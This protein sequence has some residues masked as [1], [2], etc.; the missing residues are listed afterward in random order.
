MSNVMTQARFFRKTERVGDC[1]IWQGKSR[2]GP[3]GAVGYQSKQWLAHRLSYHFQTGEELTAQDVIRHT[4]DTPLCVEGTHL[5]KGT[6]ADNVEDKVVKLRHRFGER[7]PMARFTE[8]DVRA[9]RKA[10]D[11][12]IMQKVIAEAMGMSKQQVSRIVRGD[13]WKKVRSV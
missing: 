4:C 8:A 10:H 1:L 7:H 13:R 5:R 6:H 11:E 9:V 12:G 3:Y 2:V